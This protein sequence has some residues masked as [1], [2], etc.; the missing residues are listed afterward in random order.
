MIMTHK[1]ENGMSVYTIRIDDAEK[2]NAALQPG[3]KEVVREAAK[4][5]RVSEKLCC[6]ALICKRIE[7]GRV[8]AKAL[9]QAQQVQPPSEIVKPEDN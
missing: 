9:E 1:S 5:P 6:L 4:D 8:I 2:A 7:E 3:D